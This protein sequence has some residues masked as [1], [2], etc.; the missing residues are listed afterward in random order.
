MELF[1]VY[2]LFELILCVLGWLGAESTGGGAEGEP[3][4]GNAHT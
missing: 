4:G 2:L 3:T 1:S